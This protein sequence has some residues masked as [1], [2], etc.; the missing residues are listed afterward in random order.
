MASS[1]GVGSA[2]SSIVC[3]ISHKAMK[4]LQARLKGKQES[5]ETAEEKVG[6]RRGGESHCFLGGYFRNYPL[7]TPGSTHSSAN[8]QSVSP[9]HHASPP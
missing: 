7:P 8:L 3:H 2:A 6:W 4:T 1:T 9:P 5:Q